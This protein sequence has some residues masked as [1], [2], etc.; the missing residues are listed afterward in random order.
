LTLSKGGIDPELGEIEGTKK[1]IKE[2]IGIDITILEKL[3][4]NEY[5]AHHPEKGPIRKHVL[6]FLAQANYE[7]LTLKENPGGLDQVK[8]FEMQE[9]V[10]LTMYDD[11]TQLMA[12]AIEKIMAL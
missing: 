12:M 8:W 3:G 7:P 5:I 4:E 2:E 6:Y 11:V 1:K 9:V 10:D